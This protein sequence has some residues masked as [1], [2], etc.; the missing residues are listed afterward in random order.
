MRDCCGTNG[1]MSESTP[2]SC[3]ICGAVVGDGELHERWH[4]GLDADIKKA[5]DSG[6]AALQDT[7]VRM[8][9]S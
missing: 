7:M 1:T 8:A 2:E 6:P 9:S 5:K 3:T 4:G